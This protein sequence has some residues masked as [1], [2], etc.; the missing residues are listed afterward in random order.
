MLARWNGVDSNTLRVPGIVDLARFGC[1]VVLVDQRG[2]GDSYASDDRF[3]H[4]LWANDI[5]QLAAHLGWNRFALL[6]HSYG[7]FI[8]LE[9]AVRWPQTLNNLILVSTS[10]GPVSFPT[11]TCASAVEVRELFAKRWPGLFAGPDKHWEIFDQLRFSAA[12]FNAAFGTELPRYDLRSKMVT[13]SVPSLLLVGTEDHYIKDMEW[14]ADTLPDSLLHVFENVG[15][16]PF[17]EA[18]EAFLK[19]VSNLLRPN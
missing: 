16:F 18:Q 10:A 19:V 15:H 12:P 4:E 6:G 8:A 7:G 17:V 2:H 1:E 14:L 11:A 9:Y 5:H 13:L 3:S